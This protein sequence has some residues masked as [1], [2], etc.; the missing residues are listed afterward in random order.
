MNISQLFAEAITLIK[1]VK[2]R[3]FVHAFIR[4]K[5]NDKFFDVASSSTGK[6]R[7]PEDN[8]FEGL[9][10][11]TIKAVQV[12]VCLSR[13]YELTQEQKDIVLSAVILHDTYKNCEGPF[14]QTWGIHTNYKHGKIGA[15]AIRK[16]VKEFGKE[17]N[18]DWRTHLRIK[19]IALLVEKHMSNWAKPKIYK[20]KQQELLAR[21][22]IEADYLAS[23]K[24]ISFVVPK[25]IMVEEN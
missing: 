16:C 21:I 24:G 17:L 7:P 19:Q 3:T 12:A 10:R 13:L 15:D 5:V 20:A 23:R 14:L 9:A 2:L 18:I 1:D 6:Y 11:H 4:Y 8:G 25:L 22:V